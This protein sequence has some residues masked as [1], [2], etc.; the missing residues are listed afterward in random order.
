MINFVN[1]LIDLVKKGAE[2]LRIRILTPLLFVCGVLVL[3]N[4]CDLYTI[5]DMN[6]DYIKIIL[7]ILLSLIVYKVL[8]KTTL[9]KYFKLIQRGKKMKFCK[10]KDECRKRRENETACKLKSMTQKEISIFKY[11][12]E[13]GCDAVYLPYRANITVSLLSKGCIELVNNN[14]V[15][16][17]RDLEC[18][19]CICCKVPKRIKDFLKGHEDIYKEWEKIPKNNIYASYQEDL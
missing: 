8:E 18:L 15:N 3:L 9:K 11:V 2:I 14:I 12:Y 16:I 4:E 13:M 7:I 1:M 10:I 6:Y 5:K 17:V 19:E